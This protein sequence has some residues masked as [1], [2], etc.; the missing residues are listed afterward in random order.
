MTPN[1]PE[2][3]DTDPA[4]RV[5][6]LTQR[7]V[8]EAQAG[9]RIAAVAS[10]KEAEQ[11]ASEAGLTSAA[12]AAHIN[13][14]WVLWYAGE[15]EGALVLYTEGAQ[16]AREVGDAERLQSALS[17]L[18]IAYGTLGRHA[19]SLAAYEEYLPFVS[20]DPAAGAEAH[21][22]CGTALANLGRPDEALLHFDRAE[23]LAADAGLDGPLVM[24]YLNEGL[25]GETAGEPELAFELYWKAF[26]T[27]E[28]TKDADLIG[29]AT[30]ALGAAYV[31]AGDHARAIECFTEAER[32]FQAAG[33]AIRLADV[34]Q[35]RAEALERTGAEG[36][37]PDTH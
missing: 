15:V 29:T 14:G 20:D 34:Q 21:L 16:M 13:R 28:E 11:V 9:E 22:N 2:V 10:L 24:A 26:D 27:A 18:G 36:A 5:R 33:D 7:G 8:A 30:A 23:R 12:I 35:Q 3:T 1:D 32:A 37:T 6:A 19:E 25:L 17:K 31:R 4:A